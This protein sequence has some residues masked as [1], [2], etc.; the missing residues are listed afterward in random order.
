MCGMFDNISVDEEVSLPYFPD[1]LDKTE[2]NWQTKSFHRGLDNFKLTEDGRLL[3]ENISHREKTPEEKQAE[4]EQWGFDSWDAYVSAYDEW[5]YDDAG[6]M[7]PASVDGELTHDDDTE[8]PPTFMPSRT[9]ID[10]RWWADRNYHGS[11]EFHTVLKE[12]PTEYEKMV[13][14][15][16]ESVEIPREYELDVF[17]SYEAR[18]TNGELQNILLVGR[19]DSREEII[20]E[21]KAY[22]DE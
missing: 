8:N 15:D 16:G 19:N 6:G 21:L 11:F 13:K 10:E 14:S 5:S 3:E 2:I 17:L 18:F 1:S 7:V 12:E 4:A 20:E 22:T 9:V